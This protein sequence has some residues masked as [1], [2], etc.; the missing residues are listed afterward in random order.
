LRS[1][2][3]EVLDPLVDECKRLIDDWRRELADDPEYG[4]LVGDE[5]LLAN[6]KLLQAFD[7]MSLFFCLGRDGE[8]APVSFPNI[9]STD[10]DSTTITF[11]PRGAKRV[12]VD[13]W[14]LASSPSEV[15][16]DSKVLRVPFPN[17]AGDGLR[18]A[19]VRQT[20]YRLV[21]AA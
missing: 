5:R 9:P 7:T 17:D 16:L 15:V 2:H 19:A 12:E 1:Q 13:P 14:P 11:T 18:A 6:Y 20:R 8:G 10:G 4:A 21:P 3:G